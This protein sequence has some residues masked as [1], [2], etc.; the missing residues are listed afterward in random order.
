MGAAWSSSAD[1][2][3]LGSHFIAK[4]GC[5]SSVGLLLPVSVADGMYKQADIKRYTLVFLPFIGRWHYH[6]SDCF[7]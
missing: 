7:S 3:Q 1:I 4:G 6:L 5:Y 2:Q